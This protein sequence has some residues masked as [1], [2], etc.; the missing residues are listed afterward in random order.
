MN[1]NEVI[2]LLQDNQ[3]EK[4]IKNGT[5]GILTDKDSKVMELD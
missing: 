5:N 3:N 2:S 4:G 1:Q